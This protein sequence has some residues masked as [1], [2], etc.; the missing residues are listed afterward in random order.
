LPE[1]LDFG[2]CHV[3]LAPRPNEKVAQNSVQ[4]AVAGC[5]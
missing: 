3:A 4:R 1:D 5:R 2:G